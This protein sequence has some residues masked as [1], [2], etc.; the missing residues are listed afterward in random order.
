MFRI[1][2]QT[3]KTSAPIVRPVA[4]SSSWTLPIT[5]LVIVAVLGAGIYA[6]VF[7]V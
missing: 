5:L 7:L 2:S 3:R 1:G 6:L 4:P